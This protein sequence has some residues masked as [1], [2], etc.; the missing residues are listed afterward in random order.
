MRASIFYGNFEYRHLTDVAI[1]K[2][3]D[4]EYYVPEKLSNETIKLN[5]HL[6]NDELT[7][8]ITWQPAIDQICNYYAHLYATREDDY[9]IPF[10][11]NAINPEDLY[12]LKKDALK[13]ETEYIL[14]IHGANAKYQS[15][16][17][18]HCTFEFITPTCWQFHG[19][20]MQKCRPPSLSNIDSNYVPLEN[21]LYKI[22]ITWDMPMHYPD[23]YDVS[24]NVFSNKGNCI[25][26]NVSG[27]QNYAYFSD[28]NTTDIVYDV[29][30]I[31]YS[32][33]GITAN[34]IVE[35]NLTRHFSQPNATYKFIAICILA[36]IIFLLSILFIFVLIQYQRNRLKYKEEIYSND[37]QMKKILRS[38]YNDEMEIEPQNVECHEVL[39][40]GAF[41]IVRRGLLKPANIEI[42]VKM[43]KGM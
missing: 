43:L 4:D 5:Y 27:S 38:Y 20:N 8:I 33:G 1:F 30:I 15:I 39:G 37:I 22:N 42:A 11:E 14:E 24:V 16:V 41:G 6:E 40:E 35:F 36:P 29:Q 17:G 13:F 21:G 10:D 2:T 25:W 32:K 9:L 18:E 31:A 7:S 28:V 34:D 26:Q 23:Y 3:L 19:F 12:H